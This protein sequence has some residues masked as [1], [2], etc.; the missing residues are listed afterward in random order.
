MLIKKFAPWA[1]PTV[2]AVLA[3][4]VAG[5]GG[6]SSAASGGPPQG[7]TAV[8]PVKAPKIALNTPEAAARTYIL[9]VQAVA[10]G[11]VCG[12]MDERLRRKIVG[13]IVKARPSEAHSTCAQALTG[14]IG[15]TTTPS[16]RNVALPVFHVTTTG[17]KAVVKYVGTVSHK[18]HTFVLIKNPSGW[19]VDKVNG[20]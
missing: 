18:P 1:L 20:K 15:A 4:A 12:A 2:G 14:L 6:G 13:E 10:G 3:A 19:L 16:E 9:G 17:N 7:T 8:S 5:C 11:A